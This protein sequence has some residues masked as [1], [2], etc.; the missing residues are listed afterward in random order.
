MSRADRCQSHPNSVSTELLTP[1]HVRS[2]LG[3]LLM[4][5][6]TSIASRLPLV[7]KVMLTCF[8]S[9]ERGLEFYRKL[10]FEKDAISPEVRKLRFGKEIEPDYVILSKKV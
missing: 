10:G 7:H 9:N 8:L 3:S 4:G 6:H 1:P 5:Y 2:G